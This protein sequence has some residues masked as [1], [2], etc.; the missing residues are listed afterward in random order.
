MNTSR[1]LFPVRLV[2]FKVIRNQDGKT[3]E[4]VEILLDNAIDRFIVHIPID[5]DD[6]IA[7]TSF[8]GLTM[9]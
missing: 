1:L 4:V 8:P 5:M 6:A 2:T 7:K 9:F 3:V